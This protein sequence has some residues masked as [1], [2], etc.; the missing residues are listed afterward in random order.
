MQNTIGFA[1]RSC[2]SLRSIANRYPRTCFWGVARSS[3]LSVLMMMVSPFSIRRTVDSRHPLISKTFSAIF[4]VVLPQ[5][6]TNTE[7]G[8]AKENPGSISDSGRLYVN[9][10]CSFGAVF[11]FLRLCYGKCPSVYGRI[12]M[13]RLD[14]TGFVC[15]NYLD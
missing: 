13:I 4:R 8:G 12:C 6:L 5:G 9:R 11:C 1:P 2:K 3:P 15:Y 10:N 14:M 7:C